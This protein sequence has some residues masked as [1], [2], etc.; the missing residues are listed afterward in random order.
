MFS[1]VFH[2]ASPSRRK[3]E[4]R[5]APVARRE[6]RTP[7][8]G[9]ARKLCSPMGRRGASPFPLSSGYGVSTGAKQQQFL[10]D[11][12]V[13]AEC[14]PAEGGEGELSESRQQPRLL[15]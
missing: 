3:T 10:V 9:G 13:G 15:D 12:S 1:F 8:A 5:R 6:M 2:G 7:N 14:S 4:K 11:A